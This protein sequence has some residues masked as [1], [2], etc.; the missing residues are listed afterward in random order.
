LLV[1]REVTHRRNKR[2]ASHTRTPE[3]TGIIAVPVRPRPTAAP[4][5]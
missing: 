4:R 3:G 1:D 2:L 5:P